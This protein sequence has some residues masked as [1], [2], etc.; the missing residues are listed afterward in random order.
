MKRT[1]LLCMYFLYLGVLLGKAVFS[2]D[3]IQLPV[4]ITI[5]F[6]LKVA[7]ALFTIAFPAY[8]FG[9]SK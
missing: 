7:F 2:V 8:Y 6:P 3:S 5:W 1:A 9:R 4:V